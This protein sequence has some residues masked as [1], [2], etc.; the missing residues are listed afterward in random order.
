MNEVPRSSRRREAWAGQ[1]I[2]L[3]WRNHVRG[4]PDVAVAKAFADLT[5]DNEGGR[6]V[7]SALW[8]FHE[9]VPKI[10]FR[11][12]EVE[13]VTRVRWFWFSLG[14]KFRPRRAVVEHNRLR[15]F[16]FFTRRKNVSRICDFAVTHGVEAAPMIERFVFLWLDE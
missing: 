14:I 5:L 9:P 7:L 6:M 10:E 2:F 13:S 4:V 1:A 12:E 3:T 16:Y 8:V 15:S 11:W